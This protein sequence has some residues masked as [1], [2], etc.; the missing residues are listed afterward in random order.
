MNNFDPRALMWNERY[1]ENGFAYGDKP[2]KFF[3]QNLNTLYPGT[4]LLAAEGEGRNAVYAAK[5][6]WN[7]EAFDISHVG[8][9]KANQLANKFGVTINYQ[10]G[11]LIS[12]KYKIAQFDVIA[13]IYAHFQADMKSQYHMIIQEY[14]KPG[15][16]IIFEAFSKNHL[17]YVTK[18]PMV[19]GPKDL[20]VLYSIEEIQNDFVDYHVK[21][22]NE[23]VIELNEGKY[24]I[25]LG[26]VIRFVAQK[27]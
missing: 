15:G 25:G 7:V 24:H 18:N 11:D 21:I 13:L 27:I 19:G 10:I 23:E 20:N 3:E 4:I 17:E 12:I 1:S 16:L 14:L 26:S 8:N 22:L 6:G 2:N 9:F 5:N